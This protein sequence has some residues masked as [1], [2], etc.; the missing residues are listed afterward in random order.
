MTCIAGHFGP[1]GDWEREKDLGTWTFPEPP[2]EGSTLEIGD[3]D[4]EVVTLGPD[5]CHVRPHLP[6]EG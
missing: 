5:Y 2:R 3:E 1:G 4:Y 6:D